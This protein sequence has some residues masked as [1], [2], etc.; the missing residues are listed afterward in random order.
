MEWLGGPQYFCMK[1]VWARYLKV[2]VYDDQLAEAC[3]LTLCSVK[4]LGGQ[5]LLG[6]KLRSLR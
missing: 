2:V 1:N 3:D 6:R 4:D 5:G